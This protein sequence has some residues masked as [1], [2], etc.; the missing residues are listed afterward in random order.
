MNLSQE[1]QIEYSIAAI[2]EII[3]ETEKES[4]K[5]ELDLSHKPTIFES[6]FAGLGYVPHDQ[7]IP[8]DSQNTQLRLLAQIEC[9]KID[10]ENFPE[11]GLL[12][13]WVVD[14]D[15]VGADFDEPTLQEGFRIIYFES[16]DET[17][18]EEEVAAKV[19]EPDDDESYFPVEKEVA[20][21]FLKSK[22]ALSYGDYRFEKL[23]TEKFNKLS[24]DEPIDDIFSLDFNIFDVSDK[25]CSEHLSKSGWGHKTGG[26]PSF[27]QMDPRNEDDGFDTVLLQIDSGKI[28]DKH[29]I[30]WGDMGI[31]N[32][33]INSEDLKKC[34]FSNVIYNWD[35][36]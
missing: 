8:V 32:F 6:K 27:T 30:L 25:T 24:V 2:K 26:Y 18:T 5:I 15:L 7:Q 17:V 11:K 9:S 20:L 10:L 34:D 31:C 33:F 21:K 1:K 4:I 35:C 13:F 12:Q 29:E 16:V 19:I 28:D 3:A 36:Y 22:D 23:F 14:D